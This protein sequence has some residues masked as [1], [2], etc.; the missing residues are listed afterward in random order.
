MAVESDGWIVAPF[1]VM[2]SLS[3]AALVPR[4]WGLGPHSVVAGLDSYM[5]R[6]GKVHLSMNLMSLLLCK[7]S[8]RWC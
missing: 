4:G 8:C 6:D 2:L 3:I 5:P 1:A 7:R